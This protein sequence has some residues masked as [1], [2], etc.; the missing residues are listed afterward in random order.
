M[1]EVKGGRGGEA[2]GAAGYAYAGGRMGPGGE[3]MGPETA[4]KAPTEGADSAG[5]SFSEK[6]C[7]RAAG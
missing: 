5:K 1:V 7:R 4:D 3:G 6:Y 2:P